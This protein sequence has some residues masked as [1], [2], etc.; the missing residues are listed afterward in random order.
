M[1]S[2]TAV[3][4]WHKLVEAASNDEH[5]PELYLDAADQIRSLLVNQ[6]ELEAQLSNQRSEIMRLHRTAGVY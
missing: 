5:D 4:L 6:V 3:A 1:T 2:S